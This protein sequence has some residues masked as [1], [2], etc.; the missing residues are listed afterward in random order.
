M[1]KKRIILFIAILIV[2]VC[3]GCIAYNVFVKRNMER[4]E[5]KYDE[6][7][8]T[9]DVNVTL[10]VSFPDMIRSIAVH[11]EDQ[12]FTNTLEKANKKFKEE[13]G[14]F[15]DFFVTTFNQEKVV[16]G[17]D[18]ANLSTYFVANTGEGNETD[19]QIVRYIKTALDGIVDRSIK[20]LRTRMD[21]YGMREFN[22]QRLPGGRILVEL[23]GVKEPLRAIHLLHF[24]G[25]LEIWEVYDD[26]VNDEYIQQRFYQA[27]VQLEKGHM[28]AEEYAEDNDDED[29]FS[30]AIMRRAVSG[31]DGLV[32]GYFK[33]ADIEY[34]NRLLPD[35]Q[36]V[37]G[38]K[39]VVF[40]WGITDKTKNNAMPLIPLKKSSDHIGPKL[41]SETIGGARVVRTARQDVDQNQRVI[42]TVSMEKQAADEWRRITRAAVED[43]SKL[44]Y[45]AIVLDDFI[46]SYPCIRGE[47]KNGN[48]E[49]SGNFTIEEAKDLAI[50]L[51][52][53]SLDVRLNVMKSEAVEHAK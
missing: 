5:L 38:D 49:I 27:D 9:Y 2:V 3:I 18:N 12:L 16:L 31:S 34:V 15:L 13:D 19:D 24:P 14:D 32:I 8:T 30:G 43:K 26:M 46:Y 25:K 52:S 42:V 33:E 6:N 21:Y 51:N 11:T 17:M 48:L 7:E 22:F 41:S 1:N 4:N 50:A 44:T 28:T 53:G 35:L 29:A 45:I 20:T 47:I 37:L 23:K 40:Y 39:N 36:R 10:E